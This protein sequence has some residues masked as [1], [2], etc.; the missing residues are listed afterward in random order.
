MEPCEIVAELTT[1]ELAFFK[2]LVKK[3]IVLFVQVS[4]EAVVRPISAEIS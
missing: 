1:T 3:K 2:D 4:D